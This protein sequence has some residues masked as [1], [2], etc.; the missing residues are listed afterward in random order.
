MT[1]ELE[2]NWTLG[3]P[4][5][6]GV[7]VAA[8]ALLLLLIIRFRVHAFV[9]LVLTSLLTAIAAG[10]PAGSIITTM[11]SG[12]GS[13]LASVAL[14]VGLGAMLGRMLETSGGAEVLT[15]WLIE[16]FGE[17]RAPLALSVASLLFGFPIF[18][19]AG[20][21][22]MM[23]IIFTVAR[24]LGGSLLFYGI[25]AATAFSAMHIFVPPHPGPVAAAGLLN[26]NVGLVLVFGLLVAIPTW[27]FAGHLFGKFVGKKFDIPVPDI[28]NATLG[29]GQ[30]KNHFK[31]SPSVRTVFSLL[32]LPLV[33][34]FLNTGLNM[35]G[36][37]GVVDPKAPWVQWLRLIGETP[38]A[39]IITVLLGMYLLG[40]R[41]GKEK[42]LIETIVDSALGP[43]CSIILITGAGGMFGGVLRASGIGDAIASSLE[44]VGL[45]LIV[46][47]FLIA[48]I[49]RVAQGSATVALTTAAAIIQPAVLADT[50]LSSFEVVTMVLALAAGSVF[51]SHVNDSGFW[52]ISRFFQ[53]DVPTTLRV[54][55]VGQALVSLVG[56]ACVMV[57]YAIAKMV[58]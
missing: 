44:S 32:L 48:A 29:N 30:D 45:P 20:L 54:W 55:T 37:A 28:L 18:F 43:V 8:I 51:A 49:V 35:L 27:Y 12:F 38:V 26:A 47:G 46:A 4:A 23:P 21:V 15:N 53:M 52:L 57:L 33:L 2:M 34:I 14:L 17:D 19:D 10:I 24:R 42:T 40:F 13:T 9:A 58:S 1:T 36:S 31:S 11:T 50:S 16:K 41:K 25:P 7:A 5:L 22:V 6:L 3:T 56:F 39:L